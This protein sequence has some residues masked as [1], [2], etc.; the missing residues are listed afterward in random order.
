MRVIDIAAILADDSAW[1]NQ[2][3]KVLIGGGTHSAPAVVGSA[4]GATTALGHGVELMGSNTTAGARAQIGYRSPLAQDITGSISVRVSRGRCH[5]RGWFHVTG[6]QAQ[7]GHSGGLALVSGNVNVEVSDGGDLILRGGAGGGASALLG[8]NGAITTTNQIEGDIVALVDGDVLIAGGSGGVAFAQ[9]GHGGSSQNSEMSGDIRLS[10]QGDV[11]LSANLAS[12]AYTKIGHGDDLRGAFIGVSGTGS[13]SGDIEVGAGGDVALANATIGHR[14]RTSPA[15]LGTGTTQIGVSRLDPENPAGGSLIATGASEFTGADELRFYLPRRTNNQMVAG[16]LLNGT[17]WPGPPVDPSFTRGVEE[18]TIHWIGGTP[19]NPNEHTNQFGSGASPV[20]AA[21]YAFY[22]D[23][24][25]FGA[26]PQPPVTPP[27]GSNGPG[28]PGTPAGQGLP[29]TTPPIVPVGGGDFF[30][31]D[32]PVY[33]DWVRELEARYSEP[34]LTEIFYEGYSQY[35]INGASIFDFLSTV[36][37]SSGESEEEIL[38]RHL[39][40]LGLP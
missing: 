13:R 25:V 14:N 38:R 30:F 16:T 3:G 10:A 17:I 27:S 8:H 24:L 19:A 34:G 5:P 33:D 1:G 37:D 32:D 11:A 7:I 31:S 40:Y 12:S 28:G 22:Y 29:P 15:T 23:T 39:R 36:T 18:L 26:P 9:I 4:R 35:G 6:T 20:N 21:G 2:Q